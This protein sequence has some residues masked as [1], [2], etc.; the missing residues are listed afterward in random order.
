MRIRSAIGDDDRVTTTFAQCERALSTAGTAQQQPP[1]D[2]WWDR[3]RPGRNQSRTV[4]RSIAQ[5]VIARS[6]SRSRQQQQS[7]RRRSIARGP[8]ANEVFG[9][10]DA[11][12]TVL[13]TTTVRRRMID[14]AS[15]VN[16]ADA[17]IDDLEAAAEITPQRLRP[18]L[19]SSDPNGP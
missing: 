15:L 17:L 14:A 12:R 4:G 18:R 5:R 11:R 6:S 3:S 9:V 13:P 1:G 10:F 16:Y 7:W 8:P 2:R 19:V